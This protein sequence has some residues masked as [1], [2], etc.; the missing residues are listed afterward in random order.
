[1]IAYGLR[2]PFQFEFRPGTAELWI[3]DVGWNAREEINRVVD[4][5]RAT[6]SNFGWPCYE[7]LVKSPGYDGADLNLCE[8]FYAEGA[9]AMTPAVYQYAH[10]AH[11]VANETCPTGSSSTT[12]LAFYP[13]TPTRFLRPTAA[14]CSSP[15][16]AAIA[17][18]GWP[19]GPTASRDPATRAVFL[20]PAANPVDLEIGPDGALYYADFDTNSIRRVMYSSNEPPTAVANTPTPRVARLP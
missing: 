1:M 19:R 2:N 20:A 13:E 4:P 14:V 8:A 11:V 12:G 16:T 17:S 10:S 5:S 9:G 15:T 18:G 3:G 7:G 6:V